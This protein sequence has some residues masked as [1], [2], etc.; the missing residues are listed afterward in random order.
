MRKISLLVLAALLGLT[1]VVNA[2]RPNDLVTKLPDCGDKL[3]SNWYSGYLDVSETKSLHYVF[4][5]STS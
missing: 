2:D 5:T 3:T 1:S 4:T